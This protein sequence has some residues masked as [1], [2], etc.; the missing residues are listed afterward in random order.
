ME[1]LEMDVDTA[2]PLGLIANELITNSLK[3]AF[4]NDINGEIIISIQKKH[5]DKIELLVADNGVGKENEK[6]G[7]SFGTQ[8]VDLLAAQLHGRVES[9]T[10]NGYWTK[11]VI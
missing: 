4:P 9:G 2:V 5:N 1:D 3:Y 7:T 8:L 11:L 6:I 10:E